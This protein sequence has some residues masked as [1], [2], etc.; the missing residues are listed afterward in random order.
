MIAILAAAQQLPHGSHVLAEIDQHLG[1]LWPRTPKDR[2]AGKTK[3]D[4]QHSEMQEDRAQRP[5]CEHPPERA[6]G[7]RRIDRRTV[8]VALQEN[9]SGATSH[10]CDQLA[11]QLAVLVIHERQVEQEGAVGHSDQLPPVGCGPLTSCD[12]LSVA[13]EEC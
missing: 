6:V 9:Y 1:W 8:R 3:D 11:S 13:C 4:P 5:G 2:P 12:C 7:S 10:R